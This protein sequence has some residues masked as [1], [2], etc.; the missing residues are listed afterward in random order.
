MHKILINCIIAFSAVCFSSQ[1]LTDTLDLRT[2]EH[3][4]QRSGIEAPARGVYK[5]QVESRFGRPIRIEGP[6]GQ[7]PISWWEYE[8]YYVYF[9][10]DRVLH[11]VLK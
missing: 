8:Q 3:A 1:V 7:P 9:E 6:V 11:T 4:Y 10:H 5:E 2:V